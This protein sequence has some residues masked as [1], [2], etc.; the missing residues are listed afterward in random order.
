MTMTTI[1]IEQLIEI[2]MFFNEVITYVENVL[3]PIN[4][5]IILMKTD[6]VMKDAIQLHNSGDIAARVLRFNNTKTPN[7]DRKPFVL[8]YS[9]RHN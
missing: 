1:M 2:K 5:I 4:D 9:A 8:L 7:R 3:L 6:L